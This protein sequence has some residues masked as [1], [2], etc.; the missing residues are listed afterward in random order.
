MDSMNINV[1]ECGAGS[2]LKRYIDLE[3]N[4]YSNFWADIKSLQEQ[5]KSETNIP[6]YFLKQSINNGLEVA[7][8]EAEP[9]LDINAQE[10]GDLESQL[11]YAENIINQ[12]GS[13]VAV[14]SGSVT[15]HTYLKTIHCRKQ[16]CPVCGGKGGQVH[17]SRMHSIL[18][19]VDVDKYNARQFVFTIPE[20]LRELFKDRNQLSELFKM[21]KSVIEKYFGVPIF[22]KR[23]HVKKYRLEKPVIA[24]LHAFGDKSP[25]VFMPHINVHVLES[26]KEILKIDQSI[27]D[28]INKSWLI[29]LKKY[30]PCISVVDVQYSFVTKKG[31]FI[32]KLKY[33]SRP[34]AKEDYEAITD[35]S[36]KA[37]LVLDLS[38][39]QYLR[40]WGYLSNR[41]YKDEMELNE[42][43]EGIED[44]IDEKLTYHFIQPFDYESWNNRLIE[45]N[46]GFYLLKNKGQIY[47]K[48]VQKYKKESQQ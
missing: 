47:D 8:R 15:G 6:K 24:Y 10:G 4:S 13:S 11:R 29:K 43:E 26:K 28:S 23:G 14:F 16:W 38:G 1:N 41:S 33:M 48:E 45:I 19:R 21:S 35:E 30:D 9:Y 37:L 46:E 27:L 42:V 34:W 40:Y 18:N 3:L 44:K 7:L 36:L 22:D 12:C 39:F 5:S 32:H 25:G 20:N 17:K 2:D 31:K